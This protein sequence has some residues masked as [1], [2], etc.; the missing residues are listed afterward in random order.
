M[1]RYKKEFRLRKLEN[2]WYVWFKEEQGFHTTGLSTKIPRES[3]EEI[4]RRN[5]AQYKKSVR[6]QT[7][8]KYAEKMYKHNSD[9]VKSRIADNKCIGERNGN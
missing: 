3:V 2:Y 5:P 1:G 6:E 7:L 8:R 4:I 9:H